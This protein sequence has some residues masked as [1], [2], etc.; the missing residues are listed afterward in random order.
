MYQNKIDEYKV[1]V[2]SVLQQGT[3]GNIDQDK[4][5]LFEIKVTS[6]RLNELSY[7]YSQL[8]FNV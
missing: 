1:N 3:M 5:K 7:G 6:C 4:I 8:C 2:D